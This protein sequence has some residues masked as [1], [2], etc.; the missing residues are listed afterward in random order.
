M[1]FVVGLAVAAFARTRWLAFAQ[2]AGL[3]AAVTLA[4][5][6]SFESLTSTR[7]LALAAI[8]SLLLCVWMERARSRA[9][10]IVCIVILAGSSTWVL[11]R[12]LAQKDATAA[13]FVAG[14][15]AAYV[16]WQVGSTLKVSTDPVRGAAAATALGLGTGVTAILGASAVLGVVGL[17]AGSAAAATLVVQ[18]LRGDGVTRSSSSISLPACT[19]AALAGTAAVMSA[20]LPW[21]AL[22]PLLAVAPATLLARYPGALARAASALAYAL[23]PATVAAA[24]AWFRPA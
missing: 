20:D 5:G 11:W 15:A 3:A 6:W 1:P 22:L 18:A 17:A 10:E 7:K 13:L 4:I 23:I 21:Y 12:L 24:L 14:M 9:A 19:A 16:A 2:A 8:A